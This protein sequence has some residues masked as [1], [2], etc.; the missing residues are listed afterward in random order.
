MPLWSIFRNYVLKL[1]FLRQNIECPTPNK[2][3]VFSDK[4]LNVQ[5]QIK[6]SNIQTENLYFHD[7]FCD[8]TELSA[9]N[10]FLVKIFLCS[11]SLLRN[12]FF[13]VILSLICYKSTFLKDSFSLLDRPVFLNLLFK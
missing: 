8:F 4:I 9:Q 10:K 2:N 7:D 12:I 13:N 6:I 3:Y 1:C 11:V 5:L